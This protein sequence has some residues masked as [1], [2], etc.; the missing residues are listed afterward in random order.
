[1]PPPGLPYQPPVTPAEVWNRRA[2]IMS[3][4]KLT[5]QSPPSV[6]DQSPLTDGMGQ[7]SEVYEQEINDIFEG[8]SPNLDDRAYLSTLSPLL[9]NQ[10]LVHT[11][12]RTSLL[13]Q[14]L[15][16]TNMSISGG[17]GN[18]GTQDFPINIDEDTIFDGLINDIENKDYYAGDF[19]YSGMAIENVAMD[20]EFPPLHIPQNPST[21]QG[22][23]NNSNNHWPMLDDLDRYEKLT[24]AQRDYA[25]HITNDPTKTKEEIKA[26]LQNIR[27]DMDI[28]KEDREG[29]PDALK[30]NLMEHQKV[31]LTW[32]K[33]MEEGSNKGGILADDMGLGK[34][35]QTIALMVSRPSTDPQRKTNLI[36]APVA[37]L[38]QWKAEIK[39]M[40]N[41]KDQ[42]ST[43]ILHGGH[44]KKK[45]GFA[46]LSQ[47][48]VVLT[49]YGTIALEYKKLAAW[50]DEDE[51]T[52]EPDP[53]L[54]LLGEESKWYRVVLD[55]A[56]MIKNKETQAS[57]GCAKLQSVYRLCLSGTPMQNS[58]DELYPQLRFL[59]IR[60]YNEWSQFAT[61]FSKPLKNKSNSNIS[62]T[63]QRLQALLSTCLLRRTKTSQI[64]GNPIL[65][66]P[67]KTVVVEH[68]TLTATEQ[69]FYSRLESISKSEFNKYATQ[70]SV[71]KHYSNLLVLLLRLRQAVCHE[72]LITDLDEST[73][74]GEQED[75][76]SAMELAKAL[77]PH[78]VERII[79]GVELE[80][81]QC[82][83]T[84]QNPYILP[85]GHLFCK[86]CLVQVETGSQK[87]AFRAGNEKAGTTC[88]VEDCG[89]AFEMKKGG[90]VTNLVAFKMV[91]MPEELKDEILD[92]LKPMGIGA[93]ELIYDEDTEDEEQHTDEDDKSRVKIEDDEKMKIK[94]EEVEVTENGDLAGF[95]VPDDTPDGE[96]GEGKTKIIKLPVGK[97]KPKKKKGGKK[98][99][100]PKESSPKE[101]PPKRGRTFAEV[102][103]DSLKNEKS[104]KLYKKHLASYYIPSSK[105][106]HC[107]TTI[108]NILTNDPTEKTIVFSQF[109][110]LL[111]LLEVPLTHS[112]ITHRR[113]DGS[114]TS[115]SRDKSISEFK[116]P[117]TKIQVLL[118]SLKA[119]NS[120]LNLA[121]ASQVIF[122][123]PFYNPFIEF[124]AIDR[125]HRIGQQ[126]E[127]RVTRLV[128]PGTV[129]DRVLEL[130]EKKRLLIEGALD[131]SGQKGVAKLSARDLGFLF[132]VHI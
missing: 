11:P 24:I 12:T 28:P 130:Q 34:T 118:V 57:K 51:A 59:Q 99:K 7:A 95:V 43:F 10:G 106:S 94:V 80:C 114:M 89:M 112:N 39:D 76:A 86:E 23:I 127:V 2:S 3:I 29:T 101:K 18:L 61:T 15:H 56:Q 87:S 67:G 123:D 117:E 44:G 55:E 64:D 30:I 124:Q 105:I 48:D 36:I 110:S 26:L 83:D 14:G 4:T 109:T 19:S 73:E 53:Q 31:G 32:L 78:I 13:E 49:T 81:K 37:L 65:K 68:V 1:M 79:N 22:S 92:E 96:D 120:G 111:D 16:P 116:N 6:V 74:G 75:I 38:T 71:G 21:S 69:A 47:Y 119:G 100:K 50:Q 9:D 84:P 35:M 104:R 42:L 121:A 122:M 115:S 8:L 131:E 82:S 85:C 72:F 60:P 70:N 20:Y 66:L 58:C 129:E 90:G 97:T 113:Y 93:G 98:D 5:T 45:L 52:R 63:L 17:Y 102:R 107:I 54:V 128:V 77:R 132:G 27:P 41:E 91:Y 33:R 25:H 125:A 62:N 88:I 108:R 40:L 126:R 103:K 46:A